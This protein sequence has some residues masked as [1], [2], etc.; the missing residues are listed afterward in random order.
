[1]TEKMKSLLKSPDLLWALNCDY[2]YQD[3]LKELP[4]EVVA[5]FHAMITLY[6]EEDPSFYDL[7]NDEKKWEALV[8]KYSHYK[9]KPQQFEEISAEVLQFIDN[10]QSPTLLY[11]IAHFFQ[12]APYH[13]EEDKTWFGFGELSNDSQTVRSVKGIKNVSATDIKYNGESKLTPYAALIIRMLLASMDARLKKFTLKAE[14]DEALPKHVQLL[15]SI[16]L[17]EKKATS[18]YMTLQT[19]LTALMEVFIGYYKLGRLLTDCHHRAEDEQ[20]QAHIISMI[21]R[22]EVFIYRLA[23]TLYLQFS[24]EQRL[25]E[26]KAAHTAKGKSDELTKKYEKQKERFDELRKQYQE[27]KKAPATAPAPVTKVSEDQ[28]ETV[29]GLE[30]ERTDLQ[31]QIKLL[32]LAITNAEKKYDQDVTELKKEN[33]GLQQK[34]Q[35]LLKIVAEPKI[36]TIAQWLELGK[37]LIQDIND[38]EEQE[39]RGFFDLFLKVCDEKKAT[40]PKQELATNLYGYV[41]I[42]SKGHHVHFPNGEDALITAIPAHIYLADGQFVQVTTDFEYVADYND[43]FDFQLKEP[44]AQFSIVRMKD[45]VPHVYCASKLVPLKHEVH[46]HLRD[47]QIVS[48]NTNMEL[49]RFY[50]QQRLQFNLFEQSIALKEHIPYYVQKILPTGMVVTHVLTNVESYIT[51]KNAKNVRDGAFITVQDNDIIRLFNGTFYKLSSYYTR[52]EIVSVCEVDD[53]CFGKKVNREIVIIKNIPANVA[54]TLNSHVRI[55]EHHH[56]LELIKEESVETETVEQRLSR[57]QISAIKDSIQQDPVEKMAEVLIVG[58]PSFFAGHKQKL[59]AHGFHITGIDGYESFTRVKQA[60]K[61]KDYIVVCTEFVSHDNM[62]N[63]KD[64]YHASQV[65]YSERDGATQILHQLHEKMEVA[66]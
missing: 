54:I 31:Q 24:N 4:R 62:Y 25:R 20:E 23:S 48:Y 45:S 38:T 14:L 55:D 6:K 41:S 40:L 3:L 53:G 17:D 66:V 7:L 5:L 34:L 50:R 33:S 13:I 42:S 59:A 28:S 1:M 43:F 39:I 46:I 15:Q 27:L 18:Y 63:I 30:K 21:P 64:T 60:A 61:D 56:F 36:E 22:L 37:T 44:S 47:G 12:T 19:P 58:N 65:I 52:S 2:S 10:A 29:K 9:V 16:S 32:E 35:P 11:D 51:L 57:R 26:K 49:I 8:L